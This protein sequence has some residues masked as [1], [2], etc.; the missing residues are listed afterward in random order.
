[1]IDFP[2]LS[3]LGILNGVPHGPGAA[4]WTGLAPPSSKKICDL[5]VTPARLDGPGE[6][7]DLNTIF[8]RAAGI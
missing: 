6:D 8:G 7:L 5:P 4:R 3:D 1:M 2:Y